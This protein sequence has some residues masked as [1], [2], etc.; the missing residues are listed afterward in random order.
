MSASFVYITA[1]DH[2]QALS[3]G[4]ALVAERLVACVNV[5]DGMTSIYWWNGETCE[6]HEAVL[7]AKTRT[8]LV[9]QVIERVK[10]LHS[11]KCPCVVSWELSQGNESYLQWITE[12]TRE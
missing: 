10:Q 4:R 12:Q 2:E 3:I 6:D 11:N 9:A 7:L 5:L 1:K 8:D